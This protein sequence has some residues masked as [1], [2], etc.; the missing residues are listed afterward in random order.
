MNRTPDPA[1][2]DFDGLT[3]SEVEELRATLLEGRQAALAAA[4]MHDFD[5]SQSAAISWRRCALDMLRLQRR[6]GLAHPSR[7]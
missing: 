2:F 5:G 4:A 3:E 7:P 6:L 1:W